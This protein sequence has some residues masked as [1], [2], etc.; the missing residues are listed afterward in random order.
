MKGIVW[1]KTFASAVDKLDQI[2][3][4]DIA[5]VM[6]DF[7]V[8]YHTIWSEYEALLV[9]A[10]NYGE[11]P[12]QENYNAL[13][14][15]YDTIEKFYKSESLE[16]KDSTTISFN[17]TDDI[18]AYLRAVSPY[19]PESTYKEPDQWKDRFKNG[20]VDNTYLTAVKNY[21]TDATASQSWMYEAMTNG[22]NYAIIPM[23]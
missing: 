15:Q 4:S 18:L 12:T 2:A 11:N 10:I 19:E 14:L 5:D 1:G 8:R 22:L 23:C 7:N 21:Y 9:A 20:A 16:S 6:D 17:F 13:K 3:I